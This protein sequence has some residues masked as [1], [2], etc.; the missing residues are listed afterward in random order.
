MSAL[1][2]RLVPTLA[3]AVI[4]T[5]IFAGPAGA[6]DFEG[7]IKINF[8][9]T[10]QAP[11]IRV[12]A[13][14]LKRRAKPP[15]EKELSAVTLYRKPDKSAPVEMFGF[16]DGEIVWGK[17]VTDEEKKK[18]EKDGTAPVLTTAGELETGA[19]IVVVAP[20]FEDAEYKNGTLGERS[21]NGAGLFFKKLGKTH[22]MN[23]I[24]Y[25]DFVYSYV[26][27]E[28][29]LSEL[30]KLD[31]YLPICR[32]W[33]HDQARH[34]GMTPEEVLAADGGEPPDPK[35]PVGPKK[36]EALC[37]LT[38]EYAGLGKIVAKTPY[39][40]FWPQLFGLPKRMCTAPDHPIKKTSIKDADDGAG[41]RLNAMDAALEMLVRGADP[42][43]P[44][45]LILT[46]DGR[47]G[48]INAPDDCR[49]KYEAECQ[50]NTPPDTAER[51]K[52][53]K[54][55]VDEQLSKD[56]SAEQSAFAKKL[57]V[58]LGIAKAADIRIY[59]VIHPTAPPYARE[60]LEL[61]AWRTGGTPRYAE[62][63]NE[64]LDRYDDL[65]HELNSQIVLTFVDE[66]A[67]PETPV[68]YIVEGRLGATKYTSEAFT[69]KT[70]P[71][72][73][74]S[75]IYEFKT[76]GQKKLGKVGFMAALIGVGLIVLLV[77]V[78][79]GKKIAKK[80]DG[81]MKAGAKGVKGAQGGAK[82]G[83]DAA[84]KAKEK[85]KLIEK[86]KKAKEAQKKALEKAKKKAGG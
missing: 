10:T 33:E 16:K 24:W 57:P 72:V 68:S 47:D 38:S 62:D 60:R 28:G 53:V 23:A 14:L 69:A 6:Q 66:E 48:Y 51:T 82:M 7:Q 4:A 20:G 5:G 76:F 61:L 17:E 77:F 26:Y 35:A 63:A 27:T 3:C 12:Y 25:S 42:G 29:R 43:Q 15:G 55:C 70:P 37:G 40:G 75:I 41:G 73:E 13:S 52:A 86:A 22:R 34:F 59:S 58:W 32:K 56:A 81:A 31:Q 11:K 79:I 44:R 67:K 54:K 64:V 9:D 18:K 65:I 83:G 39:D 2:R 50:K 78:K 46:G 45:I 21:R 71:K 74:R 49:V 8:I 30:A 36:G 1:H 84:K 19:A 85:A 80:G